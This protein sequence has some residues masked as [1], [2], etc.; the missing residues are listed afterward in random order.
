MVTQT[1]AD[2]APDGGAEIERALLAYLRG[3]PRAADTID[4]I[5]EWWLPLQRF[6]T[7]REC[8]ER[9]L[10]KLAANGTL[11][12]ESLHDGRVLYA[13]N[14]MQPPSPPR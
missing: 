3:H 2:E 7:A 12:R 13:L 11:R 4:G 5:V 6:A 8:V 9:A 14:I 1:H 10:D